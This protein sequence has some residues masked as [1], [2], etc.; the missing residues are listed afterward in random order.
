MN[1]CK[2]TIKGRIKKKAFYVLLNY[3][4][5]LKRHGYESEKHEREDLS[6]AEVQVHYVMVLKEPE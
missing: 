4:D 1:K 6:D 3:I 5:G 2:I